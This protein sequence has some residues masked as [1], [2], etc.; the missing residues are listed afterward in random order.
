MTITLTNS[1]TTIV[2]TTKITD[3]KIDVLAQAISLVYW[4]GKIDNGNFINVSSVSK[5][6]T[7]ADFT[8]LAS[9]TV[10]TGLTLAQ[11]VR[12]I[13]EDKL[14]ADGTIDGTVD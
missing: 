2:T 4:K 11:A 13:L 10:P 7:G 5:T 9:T 6:Y 1:E 14:V 3:I 12:K 8:S